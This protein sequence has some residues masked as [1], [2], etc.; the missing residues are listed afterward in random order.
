MACSVYGAQFLLEAWDDKY[1]PNQDWNHAWGAAPGNI[2]P[3]YLMGIR[4][5]TPGFEKIL[6][7]PAPASLRH[8]AIT[9]STIKGPVSVAFENIP[10]TPFQLK[11]EIPQGTTAKIAIPA[12]PTPSPT[13]SLNGKPVSTIQE[14]NHIIIDS[15]APGKHTISLN[16]T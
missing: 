5:M 15:I 13:L 3:R 8:A 2:I 11:V 14:N 1:K 10:D 6:I 4:P 12:S 16:A 7:K 9:I